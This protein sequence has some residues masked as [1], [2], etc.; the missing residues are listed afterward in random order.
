MPLRT[1]PFHIFALLPAATLIACLSAAGT[2][3]ARG[4]NFSEMT[5]KSWTAQD[6]APQGVNAL[7][8]APDGILWVGSDS[9]LYSFDGRNFA[10]FQSRPGDAEL[11]ASRVESVLVS[12]AGEIWVGFRSSGIARISH[13][14]VTLFDPAGQIP[15]T[16]IQHMRQSSD[17]AIW[18]LSRQRM[19]IRFGADGSWRQEPAPLGDSGGP[20]RDIF[21]DSSDTLWVDQGRRLYRR[22][23]S[24]TR[25]FP[26]ETEADWVF[27]YV[28][29][30]DHSLW[31]ADVMTSTPEG[32]SGRIRH[33]DPDGKVL[34]R[35]PEQA[36]TPQDLLYEPDGSLVMTSFDAGLLKW[37]AAALTAASPLAAQVPRDRYGENNG[38]SSNAVGPLLRDNDGNLWVGGRRGLDRFRTARFVVFRLKNAATLPTL[39]AGKNGD[40][41]IAAGLGSA[42]VLY[43]VSGG[44]AQLLPYSTQV[45]SPFCGADGDTWLASRTGVWNIH[46][47]RFTALPPI[48]GIS[49][50]GLHEVLATPDHTVFATVS[51]GPTNSGI[52]RY[53]GDS[54]DR[55]VGPGVSLHTPGIVYMDAHGRLWAGYEQGEVGLPLED[56]GKLL[57]SGVGAVHAILETP[58]GLFAGGVNGLAVFRDNHFAVLPLA[59]H[60]SAQDIAGL[61]ESD[62]GDLWLNAAHGI[63]RVSGED[64][65]A[66]LR[67]LHLPLKSELLTEG[68]FVGPAQVASGSTTTGR[69]AEGNL[70]FATLSGVFHIDP[71]HLDSGIHPPILSIRSMSADQLPVPDGGAIG[72]ETQTLVIR[73]LGVNL[74]T[75]ERVSYKYKLDG[76]DDAW[77]DAGHRTEAIYAHLRPKAY[78]FHVVASN[79]DGVWTAAS[80][81]AFMVQPHFYQ[82]FWFLMLC[83]LVGLLLLWLAIALRL[84]VIGHANR[85]RAE[86]QNALAHANRLAAM[87][88]VTASIA[89][90]VNQPISGT[91]I[92]ARVALKVLS[93]DAPDLQKVTLALTRIVRDNDRA[94]QVVQRVREMTKNAPA[95]KEDVSLNDAIADVLDMAHWQAVKHQI[96][97]RTEFAQELPII[98]GDRVQLQQ[99]VL[100]LINNAIEAMSGAGEG[101]GELTVRTESGHGGSAFVFV[102]DSGPGLAPAAFTNLFKPFNTTKVNG[103]GLG[104]S[105]CRSIVE[106]HGGQ[107]TARENT[108][109]GTVF[110][111]SVP[112][113][114]NE[115]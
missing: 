64:L 23:L 60:K 104:L 108:P 36:D 31:V 95:T 91:A 82:T 43:K 20:M 100:N 90:E 17:G 11:P 28:E 33:I 76:L 50:L 16:H 22:P 57:P 29:A 67:D 10:E 79:G 44:A 101:A 19:I 52:W 59:D 48:P 54:W 4:S 53:A 58:Q 65:K 7:A 15:L 93:A 98:R 105:I 78:T 34:A 40:V 27:G 85:I 72:P 37:P 3:S 87:G 8:Q 112:G 45:V 75:P 18:A 55:V 107:L 24:Q 68:D 115:A 80:S 96:S 69:D 110:Q 38:L 94:A 35:L 61:V 109:R 114:A 63:V 49:P 73:Y 81:V 102:A 77:Q 89:H 74:T 97:V 41:W 103:L 21:I 6:G 39:C 30:P 13:G 12:R 84:R 9:G 88:Q 5:H 111:F 62:N 86:T 106:A 70:W 46:A 1:R 42:S 99:V 25:F 32:Q 56:G 83:I 71:R 14:R 26:T 66:T 113:R 2:A 92:N 47:D 51:G